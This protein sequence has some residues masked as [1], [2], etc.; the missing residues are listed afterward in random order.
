MKQTKIQKIDKQISARQIIKDLLVF[1]INIAVIIGVY[2]GGIYLNS[3]GSSDVGF[4]EYF[5][6]NFSNFLHLILSLILL[7]AR[8]PER[9]RA[10]F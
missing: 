10:L 4:G 9:F 3:L 7:K 1:A 5:A 6:G 8:N 2:V